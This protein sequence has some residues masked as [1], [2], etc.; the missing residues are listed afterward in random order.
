MNKLLTTREASSF[1]EERFGVKR[2]PGT[3]A[4]ARVVGGC[5][6]PH[7]KLGRTVLYDPEDL[8]RWVAEALSAPRRS[9]SEAAATSPIPAEP[10]YFRPAEAPT[11]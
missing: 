10:R 2:S 5:N 1:L 11:G 7:R 4:K 9:T 6:P 8:C 3:L